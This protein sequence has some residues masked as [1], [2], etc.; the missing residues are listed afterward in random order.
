MHYLSGEL[1]PPAVIQASQ[2][3]RYYL[4]GKQDAQVCTHHNPLVWLQ[5]HSA[6]EAKS[7]QGVDIC[8]NA[9]RVAFAD[10]TLQVSLQM[11]PFKGC[12]CPV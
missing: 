6:S 7:V 3:Q 11:Q 12:R 5:I 8:S 2:Y 10:S 1:E 9:W 4:H